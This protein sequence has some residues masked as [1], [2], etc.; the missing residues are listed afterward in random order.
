MNAPLRTFMVFLWVSS[1]AG[2]AVVALLSIGWVSWVSFA[3]AGV[4]GLVA[5]VPAGI[6]TARLIKQGDPDWPPRRLRLSKA[7]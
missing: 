6:W 3:I 7:G 5:G 1:L 4:V 2:A